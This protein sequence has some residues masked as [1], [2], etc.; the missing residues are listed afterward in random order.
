MKSKFDVKI[1]GARSNHSLINMNLILKLNASMRK[2]GVT[3]VFT[4]KGRKQKYKNIKRQS[5][6]V[7]HNNANTVK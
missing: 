5:V 6:R 1:R 2:N 7:A 3:N 4:L